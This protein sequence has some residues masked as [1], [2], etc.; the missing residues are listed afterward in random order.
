M[1]GGFPDLV[2]STTS[3]SALTHGAELPGS[4]GRVL[5]TIEGLS[6]AWEGLQGGRMVLA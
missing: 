4:R 2:A 5:V 3:N 6:R 1:N